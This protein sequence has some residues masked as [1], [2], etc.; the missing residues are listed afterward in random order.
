MRTIEVN[1][2][3]TKQLLNNFLG[4]FLEKLK[5]FSGRGSKVDCLLKKGV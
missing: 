4:D 2:S 3:S 5:Q 1:R